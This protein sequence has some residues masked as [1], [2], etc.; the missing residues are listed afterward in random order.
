MCDEAK[1]PKW[2][3]VNLT[4][5]GPRR[6]APPPAPVP[7]GDLVRRVTLQ[8]PIPTPEEVKELNQRKF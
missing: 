3:A 4:D 5:P 1:Y 6:P 8:G 7:A 2:G